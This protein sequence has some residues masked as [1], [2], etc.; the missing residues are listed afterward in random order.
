MTRASANTEQGRHLGRTVQRVYAMLVQSMVRGWLVPLRMPMRRPASFHVQDSR[1]EAW[2]ARQHAF[3][4]CESSGCQDWNVRT[5][6]LCQP[7]KGTRR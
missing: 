2:C 3:V 7:L 6:R 4:R 5:Q 1:I